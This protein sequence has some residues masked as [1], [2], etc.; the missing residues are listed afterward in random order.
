MNER[1]LSIPID[2]VNPADASALGDDD[3]FINIPFDCEIVYVSAGADTDD[4]DLTLDINDDATG[5]IEGIDCADKED[6]GEWISTHFGG[7]ETPVHVDA[8]SE[9]SFDAND[10]AAE[11]TIHGY[12]LV[13]TSGVYS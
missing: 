3:Y 5:V 11:T 2:M 12:M 10:A 13:L 7:A 9:L 8:G 1:L 4:P 6:P